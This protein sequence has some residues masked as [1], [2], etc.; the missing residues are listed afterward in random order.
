VL[1]EEDNTKVAVK[2]KTPL[3]SDSARLVA[4]GLC[5]DDVASFARIIILSLLFSLCIK[6]KSFLVLSL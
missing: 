6:R 2:R 3:R 4:Y 5:L 1:S